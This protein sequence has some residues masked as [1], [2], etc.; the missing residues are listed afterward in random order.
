MFGLSD[1]IIA[2]TYVKYCVIG[3][4]NWIISKL[5]KSWM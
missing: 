3:T 2:G 5:D 1:N 4:A